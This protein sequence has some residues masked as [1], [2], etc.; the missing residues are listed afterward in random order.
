[1]DIIET[2]G[3]TYDYQK[4]I[5]ENSGSL[6]IRAIDNI[7]LKIEAGKFVSI[8]GQNGSGK[9]TLAKLLAALL[10][11]T[12]GVLYIDGK[13]STDKAQMIDICKS[14]GIVF[15]NPDNQMVTSIVEDDVAFG[16][17]NIGIPTDE[18]W[19]RVE[20]SLKD[21]DMLEYRHSTI[22]KLSGGQKQR[23]AIAGIL[24]MQPKCIILDE[25]TAMLDP[26]GR[27]EVIRTIRE[28]NRTKKIT[29]I[30]ITH[31]IDEVICSD[32]IIVINAG[33]V[34]MNGNPP[35]VFSQTKTLE[36]YGLAVPQATILSNELKKSGISLPDGIADDSELINSIMNYCKQM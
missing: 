3:I 4:Y 31:N 11:P 23:I 27:N 1:M 12:S 25:P 16:P 18:I 15:Q 13:D 2:A 32:Q 19:Q 28:L 5:D 8:L 10:E 22:N 17:E 36:G 33:K 14:V 30:M 29:I 26:Q 34:V 24:A 6:L 21:V 20:K 7:A 35:Y 9:S